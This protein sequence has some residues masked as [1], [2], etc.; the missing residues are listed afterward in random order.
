MRSE[1]NG[2]TRYCIEVI[3]KLHRNPLSRHGTNQ[4]NAF[5]FPQKI[6]RTTGYLFGVPGITIKTLAVS[7]SGEFFIKFER[8]YL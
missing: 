5:R 8:M 1:L 3:S 7:F 4:D 6:F 2:F